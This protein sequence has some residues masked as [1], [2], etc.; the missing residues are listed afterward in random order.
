MN[1][2][3]YARATLLLVGL[4]VLVMILQ[5]TQG[6]LLPIIYATLIAIALNPS[7][8]FLTQRKM[9]H[10]LAIALVLSLTILVVLA[11][12][13]LLSAQATRLNAAMPQLSAKSEGLFA[14]MTHWIAT[15][16][17]ITEQKIQEWVS[18]G[19][20]ELMTHSAAAIGSTLSTVGG[21]LSVGVLTPVYIF[22]ILSYKAHLQAFVHQVFGRQHNEKVSTVLFKTKTIVQGYL[23]GLFVEFAIVGTLNTICLLLLGIEY[24][25]LFGFIGALLNVVPYIGG[26]VAVGLFML[27]A[28]VTKTPIYAFYVLLLYST[29]QF[30]D[31]HYIVPKIIG[32]KVKLNALICLIAVLLGAA[33]WGIPGM[34][35]SIPL[36]AILKL[37]FDHIEGLEAWGFLL[38]DESSP[39]FKSSVEAVKKRISK[40]L[41][42]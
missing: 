5:T 11:V 30:I 40:T 15:H 23:S 31:N 17:T 4:Y 21:M 41:K 2:P 18:Q 24:A 33:L 7:V 29:I 12:V 13:V 22:M 34:F 3:F 42:R 9:N 28:F 6:I 27:I 37:I 16:S 26:I 19:R 35:L 10:T 8:T 1:F 39:V 38:G 32:S 14:Q 36:T 20:A 25:I